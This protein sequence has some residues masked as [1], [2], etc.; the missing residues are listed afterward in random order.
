[1]KL[2]EM[3]EK[4][5]QGLTTEN[6]PADFK[7][8]HHFKV[9]K[10][11]YAIRLKES[12]EEDFPETLS[13]IENADDVLNSY[14]KAHPSSSWTLAE[15]AQHFP[16]FIRGQFGH[17]LFISASKEW[18]EW[19]AFS[20]GSSTEAT[21]TPPTENVAIHLNPSLQ[22]L[23]DQDT[24]F[25]IYYWNKELQEERIHS[26]WKPLI[27]DSLKLKSL[28]SIL[29]GLNLEESEV[30]SMVEKLSRLG[31]ILGFREGTC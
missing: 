17:E 19:V 28:D 31:I 1:M 13:Q 9:Y 23:E 29:A 18:L 20:I 21:V 2:R 25:L 24:L 14:I 7:S 6:I 11:A 12:L 15:F 26:K 27:E 4:F 3:Q 10:N 5:L 30:V 16:E 22:M 8:G